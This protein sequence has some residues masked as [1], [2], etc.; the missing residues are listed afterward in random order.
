VSEP[1]E[2]PLKLI[3]ARNLISIISLGA[4]LVDAVIASGVPAE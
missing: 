2:Q 3:L 1:E 4:L